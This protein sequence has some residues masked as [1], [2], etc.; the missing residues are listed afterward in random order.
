MMIGF[1]HNFGS[2]VMLL[3]SNLIGRGIFII[4][5]KKKKFRGIQFSKKY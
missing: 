3:V 1:R 4:V 5:S 2:I